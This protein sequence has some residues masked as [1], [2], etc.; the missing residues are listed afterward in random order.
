MKTAKEI[1]KE[2]LDT[3]MEK[4]RR[5]IIELCESSVRLA[6]RKGFTKTTI[7]L[8]PYMFP[9]CDHSE[10]KFKL[11]KAGYVCKIFF[12]DYPEESFIVNLIW[13]DNDANHYLKT[14]L[15]PKEI[16]F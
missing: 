6:I 10:L 13:W 16:P 1:Y 7:Q 14:P 11:E 9:F 12:R 3:D 5:E 15:D 4:R 8:K 2:V